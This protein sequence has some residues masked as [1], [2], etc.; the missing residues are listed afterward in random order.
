EDSDTAIQLASVRHLLASLGYSPWIDPLREHQHL[1]LAALSP[2]DDSDI[3]RL[4]EPGRSR[5]TT[6][7]LAASAFGHRSLQGLDVDDAI[8]LAVP[9]WAL[10]SLQQNQL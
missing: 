10:A 3:F 4:D 8:R 1:E 5:L 7:L 9:A 6:A 2:R